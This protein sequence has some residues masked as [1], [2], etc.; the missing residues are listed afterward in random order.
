[1]NT[2]FFIARRYFFSKKKKNFINVISIL[3]MSIVGFATIALVVVLS[4]FNGLEDLIR[5][6]Y[7]TFDPEIKI[8]AAKGKSFEV[9]SAFLNKIRQVEGV[10]IITEVIEDWAHMRHN[11]NEKLVIVKGV[12]PNFEQHHRM[13][14]MIVEGDFILEKGQRNFAIIGRGI[15]QDLAI[16]VYDD[17]GYAWLTYPMKKEGAKTNSVNIYSNYQLNQKT[18]KPGAVFAIEKQYDDKFVFV[19]LNFAKELMAF[20]NKRTGLEIKT[21]GGNVNEVRDKLRKLLGENFLVLNSDE[22]HSSLLKAIKIEK[23]FVCFVFAIILIIASVNIFFCLTM[24]A[25][26]KKKDVA[27]LSSLGASE[28]FIRNLFLFEGFIIAGIGAFSGLILGV[29]I[30]LAQQTFGFVS[31]GM[32]TA[33]VDAYPVKM[34]VMDFV[35]TGITIFIITIT[36]S[37]RP[38]VKAS[39][40]NLRE[41]LS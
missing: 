9:D 7:N 38:A 22:Q 8:T 10:D 20:D 11:K 26:D 35:F 12:S 16:S 41:N 25:V 24:L 34:Q 33:I 27:V 21:K 1:M 28:K 13:D 17:L 5:S 40:F 18:I 3:S 2:A 39:R 19:P 23:L 4:V 36:I 6:L 37:Y 31:M 14:S 15:Q 30:C 32:E 29:V